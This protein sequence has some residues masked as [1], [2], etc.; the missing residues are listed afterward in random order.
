MSLTVGDILKGKYDY[1]RDNYRVPTNMFVPPSRF[2]DLSEFLAASSTAPLLTSF[3]NGSGIKIFG[4]FI[5]MNSHFK[6]DEVTF[7]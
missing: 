2:D 6:G 1:E 4:L 7:G 5:V 3:G